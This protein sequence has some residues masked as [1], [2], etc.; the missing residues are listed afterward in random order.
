MDLIHKTYKDPH[1]Y[2]AIIKYYLRELPD[3]LFC[4]AFADRWIQ[5]N[6]IKD[7]Q[8]RMKEIG[9]VLN[10]IPLENKENIKFLFEF[11]AQ[12]VAEE[13]SNKMTIANLVTVLAPNLLWDSQK[14][15]IYIGNVYRSLIQMWNENSNLM[16][17]YKAG[18][19]K[20]IRKKA[21]EDRFSIKPV[22]TSRKIEDKECQTS[23]ENKPET[24][25][26]ITKDKESQTLSE[27]KSETMSKRTDDKECQTS[28]STCD[29]STSVSN[30]KENEEVF[31]RK[32]EQMDANERKERG[33]TMQQLG[34]VQKNFKDLKRAFDKEKLWNAKQ[35]NPKTE[36]GDEKVETVDEN[37]PGEQLQVNFI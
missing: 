32:R 22:L 37:I 8:E 36:K 33:F 23:S 27:N 15:N 34:C 31:M 3:P 7:N 28:K 4:S 6:A 13:L 1:I 12:L 19:K 35:Q 11:L 16:M 5:V 29:K 9:E 10:E 24:K 21:K 26:K 25:S 18:K 14:K 30:D 20:S 2:T 17:A